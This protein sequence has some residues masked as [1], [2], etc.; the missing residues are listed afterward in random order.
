MKELKLDLIN[1]F[2]ELI[3]EPNR[4]V[5]I[6]PHV[7]PDGDAIGSALGMAHIIKNSGLQA[8]VVCVNKYADFFNWMDDHESVT[9]Y[10]S[11]PK[12]VEQL[13]DNSDLLICVDFNH[14]SRTG[15]MKELVKNYSKSTVLIDHH[16]YPQDFA[17]VIIS[18]PE[19]S[20]TAELVFHVIRALD[21][22][23]YMN[24]S[25]AECL[26]CGIMT[27]TGSFDYNVS[28][29]QT[30]QTVGELLKF[31]ID[32]DYIHSQ[33]FDNYSADRMRLL[34]YCLNECMEVFPEYHAAVIYLTKETQAKFNFV[35]GDSEG[36]V[37]YPLS[38]R[39]IHFS[40]LFSEK[41]GMIK[42]SFRSKGEFAVNEFASENFN[43]G[44]HCNA[45]GGEV[46]ASLT[47]T[48]DK[49]R[50]LLPVYQEK[51]VKTKS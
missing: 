24:K 40:T 46:Y 2:K 51:L 25:A 20:S 28:D 44:G 15:K 9:F 11:E 33:V 48:L 29:P 47:E 13:L 10:S 30:F 17:D 35:K 7:N 45:A 23:Q 34:G 41:D 26:F 49:Y 1:A 43:G 18:H 22:Q 19:C 37:N 42:A 36:F 3:V 5:V 21:F 6:L 14:L 31:G 27:D 38:I 39:G 12:K 32:Q 4:R 50:K 8:N 16:P